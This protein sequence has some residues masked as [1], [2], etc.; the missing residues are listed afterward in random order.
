MK[1]QENQEGSELNRISTK[2]VVCFDYLL[3]KKYTYKEICKLLHACKKVVGHY[4]SPECRKK[5]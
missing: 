3:T 1:V 4:L 2:C 5:S